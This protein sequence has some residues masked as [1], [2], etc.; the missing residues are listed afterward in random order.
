MP[1]QRSSVLTLFLDCLSYLLGKDVLIVKRWLWVSLTPLLESAACAELSCKISLRSNK[2]AAFSGPFKT[3][4]FLKTQ[5]NSYCI[6]YLYIHKECKGKP[7]ALVLLLLFYLFFLL[8]FLSL[9]IMCYI[10]V[11][12]DTK[13]KVFCGIFWYF[14]LPYSTTAC[15]SELEISPKLRYWKIETLQVFWEAYYTFKEPFSSVV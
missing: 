7:K 14:W 2:G 1:L 10:H 5:K 9:Y 8:I 6:T 3:L 13:N 4:Q 11:F 15:P 12:E